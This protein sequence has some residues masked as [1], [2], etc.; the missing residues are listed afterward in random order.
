MITVLV[1]SGYHYQNFTDFEDFKKWIERQVYYSEL[2]PVE[3]E[4]CLQFYK[5]GITLVEK[6]HRVLYQRS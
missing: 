2:L 3:A 4:L 5:L 6:Q 1:K